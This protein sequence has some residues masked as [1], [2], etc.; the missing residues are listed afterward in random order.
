MESTYRLPKSIRRCR[1][2]DRAEEQRSE[3]TAQCYIN[4]INMYDSN[5][6]IKIERESEKV[7]LYQQNYFIGLRPYTVVYLRI[8]TGMT[9][10]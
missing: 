5:H 1:I 3:K 9:K 2:L 8:S 7:T 10:S 6:P 4:V